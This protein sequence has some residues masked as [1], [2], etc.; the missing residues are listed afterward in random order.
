LNVEAGAF[1]LHIHGVTDAAKAA[2]LA[3]EKVSA[4]FERFAIM[5]GASPEPA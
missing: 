2:E 5:L 1:E 3:E 4:V